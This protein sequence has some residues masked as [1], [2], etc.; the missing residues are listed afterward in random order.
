MSDCALCGAPAPPPFRAPTAETAP[1]LDLRP[2]EPTR[3]SL[4]RWILQCRN[5]GA[6]GPDLAVLP[7]A[8]AAITQTRSYRGERSRFRRWV[9]LVAGT[10]VEAEALLQAAWEMDDQGQDATLLRRQAAAVWGKPEGAEQTLRL[11]DV[12]RRAGAFD[13]AAALLPSLA[14][15]A[16][17]TTRRIAAFQQA[18]IAARDTG[19]HLM[20]SALRPPATKPHVAHGRSDVGFWGRLFG[21][22]RR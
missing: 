6:C 8:A 14:N 22:G 20:S 16:D 3:S 2:G 18:R 11:V 21:G 19:R 5:C 9:M 10:P 12:L 15:A 1:D 4:S 17:D 13:E 7:V